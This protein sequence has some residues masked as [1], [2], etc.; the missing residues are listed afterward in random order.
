MDRNELHSFIEGI[1]NRMSINQHDLVEECKKQ[2]A[3]Y[4]EVTSEVSSLKSDAKKAKAFFDYT[5]ADLETK[6]RLNPDNYDLPK[7]TAD[8][9]AAKVITQ[10][11]Y[12]DAI[13]DM[14][15]KESMA[16]S[17][18]AVVIALEQRKSMIRDMVQLFVYDYHQTKMEANMGAAGKKVGDQEQQDIMKNSSRRSHRPKPDADADENKNEHKTD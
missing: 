3:F 13:S 9:V 16:E 11:E 1:K 2:P 17:L 8:A 6:I 18:G 7:A 5:K 15:D 14:H 4:M 10:K 12:R